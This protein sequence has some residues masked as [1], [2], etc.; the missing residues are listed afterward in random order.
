MDDMSDWLR[1]YRGN[2]DRKLMD[3]KLPLL[4]C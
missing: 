1:L 4:L 3:A 2:L